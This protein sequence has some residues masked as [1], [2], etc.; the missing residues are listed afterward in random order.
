MRD[1]VG[2]VL[3]AKGDGILR[4]IEVGWRGFGNGEN[5][6]ALT[7][8]L[9]RSHVRCCS[10]KDEEGVVHCGE[11]IISTFVASILLLVFV[12]MCDAV[13]VFLEHFALLEGMIDRALV[14]RARLLKHVV[15][16]ATTTSRGASRSFAVWG[17]SEGLL[18]VLC[19]PHPAQVRWDR[20]LSLPPPLLFLGGGVG[21][22]VAALCGRIVFALARLVVEDGINSLLAGAR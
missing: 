17:G 3:V 12:A 9:P 6:L 16:L 7:L 1:I 14:V 11:L 15:E 8:A 22:D 4:P 19:L 5:F 10:S 2:V 21:L 18:G 13:V 20:L